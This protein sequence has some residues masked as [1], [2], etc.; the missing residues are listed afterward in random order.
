M[1]NQDYKCTISAPV[2]PT[3]AYDTINAIDK[4]WNENLEGS[5]TNVGDSFKVTFGKTN[6]TFKITETIPGNKIVWLVTDCHMPWLSNI[7][8]WTGTTVVWNIEK[9]G[10]ST[11]ITLTHI[12]LTPNIECYGQCESGWNYYIKD[13]LLKLLTEGAGQPENLKTQ[14]V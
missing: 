8:E 10:E 13:S 2:T 4:W 9:I 14:T 6:K 7:T 3:E 5:S 1:E 12:G 11:Q